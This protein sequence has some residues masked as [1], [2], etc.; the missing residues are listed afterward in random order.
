MDIIKLFYQRV[1]VKQILHFFIK[2]HTKEFEF[3]PFIEQKTLVQNSFHRTIYR[4]ADKTLNHILRDMCSPYKKR[5]CHTHDDVKIEHLQKYSVYLY[6]KSKKIKTDNVVDKELVKLPVSTPSADLL[7]KGI[8]ISE[9]SE[10]RNKIADLG[11]TFEFVGTSQNREAKKS[12]IES[13][14]AYVFKDEIN[15]P[16]DHTKA[17][18]ENQLLEGSKK[19]LKKL[20]I[21]AKR[22]NEIRESP[23][24]TQGDIINLIEDYYEK[25]KTHNLNITNF[26]EIFTNE[27][28]NDY[29]NV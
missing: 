26:K 10:T 25:F 22:T 27:F 14:L 9:Q 18:L 12:Y 6:I 28:L 7:N 4:G 23:L 8:G 11:N 13:V 24:V 21:N 20:I 16:V 29:G 3:I 5:K 15:W 1:R 17:E 19:D 2:A